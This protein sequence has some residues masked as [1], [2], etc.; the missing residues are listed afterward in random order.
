MVD[1]DCGSLLPIDFLDPVHLRSSGKK[2]NNI[3]NS[4]FVLY[5]STV[6]IVSP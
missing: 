4:L 6:I 2:M 3:S 1:A 5:Y